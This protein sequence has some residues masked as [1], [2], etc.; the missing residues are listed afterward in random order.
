MGNICCS[1]P[2]PVPAIRLLGF[3]DIPD[4][5]E[6]KPINTK[7]FTIEKVIFN[8][9]LG[10]GSFGKVLLV[11]KNDTGMLYAMKVISKLKLSTS[12]RKYHAENERKVLAQV[13]SPFIVKMR[14][15]FQNSEKLYL[16]LDFMQGGELFHHLRNYGKFP[17]SIA[18]FYAA[19]VVLALEDLH[20]NN[21]IYRDLKPENLLLDGEGHVHLADFNLAKPESNDSER[22]KTVCGTPEYIAPEV[23]RREK[24]TKAVDYWGLGVLLYE[25]IEGRSP[26]FSPS[27][28]EMFGKIAQANYHFSDHFGREARDLVF[29]LLQPNPKHRLIETGLIM[30]H[31]FFVG[32]EWRELR[33]KKTKPPITPQIKN[34]LDVRNFY[35][36]G[37]NNEELSPLPNWNTQEK[38]ANMFGGFTYTEGN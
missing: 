25:M 22:T 13:E 37:F 26:F 8:Q 24:Q 32:I 14:Y 21:I 29:K 19:E 34:T 18:R 20:A 6:S 15:A 3:S 31:D 12:G 5:F 2:I 33:Y 35:Q 36:Q 30:K 11:R 4:D 1:Q 9:V 7:S 28:E 16:V 17:I 23:L 38:Q 10:K 27:Y